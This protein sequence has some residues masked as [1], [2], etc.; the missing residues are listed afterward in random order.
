MLLVGT[1]DYCPLSGSYGTF[2][3]WRHLQVVTSLGGFNTVHAALVARRCFGDH[4]FEE[5]IRRLSGGSPQACWSLTTAA[6][7]GSVQELE[8]CMVGETRWQSRSGIL[9]HVDCLAG[10]DARARCASYRGQQALLRH[11]NVC[12][13][14]HVRLV[15]AGSHL[16][17]GLVTLFGWVAS[18][19]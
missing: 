11:A 9:V 6:T 1:S 7:S 19:L 18:L 2:C 5:C 13:G 8:S 12:P 4:L 3:W 16:V 10:A 17:H 14:Q 15:Q